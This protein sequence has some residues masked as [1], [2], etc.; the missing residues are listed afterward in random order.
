MHKRVIYTATRPSIEVP[1]Y[2]WPPMVV[3]YVNTTYR[4]TGKIYSRTFTLSEDGLT[5][6]AVTV[7]TDGSLE[8]WTNDPNVRPHRLAQTQY[9]LDN[10]IVTTSDV[11]DVEH[12]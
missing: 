8:E 5:Q 7:W 4:D 2:A 11:Q 9:N 3:D 1:F 12:S 6:M 10:N